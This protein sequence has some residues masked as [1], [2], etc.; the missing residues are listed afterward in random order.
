M[1]SRAMGESAR[2]DRHLYLP[3]SRGDLMRLVVS[4]EVQKL[5]QRWSEASELVEVGVE[6]TLALHFLTDR[7]EV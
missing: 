1:V 2:G 4:I 6:G 7:R 5:F 3:S